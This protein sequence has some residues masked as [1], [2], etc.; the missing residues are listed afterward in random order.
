MVSAEVHIARVTPCGP[1]G[2]KWEGGKEMQ[3]LKCELESYFT[4]LSPSLSICAL[5]I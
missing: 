1:D 5:E 4:L 3:S 2:T